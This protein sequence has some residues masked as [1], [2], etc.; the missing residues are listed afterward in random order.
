MLKESLNVSQQKDGYRRLFSDEYFDL[1]IWYGEKD[2]DLIGFQLCYNKK[3]D[4]HSLTWNHSSGYLHSSID[5]GES[6][7]MANRSP[8]LVADG[9]FDSHLIADKFLDRSLNLDEDITQL[10]YK[11]LLEYDR[12][13]ENPFL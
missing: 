1:F 12:S 10:V 9:Y 8:I 4:E 5:T 13:K 7:P 2:H 11:K 3:Y 6:S